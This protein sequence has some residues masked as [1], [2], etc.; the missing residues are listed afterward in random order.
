MDPVSAEDYGRAAIAVTVTTGF[1]LSRISDIEHADGPYEIEFRPADIDVR[2]ILNQRE[3]S[4]SRKKCFIGIR[5][6]PS[7][8][9]WVRIVAR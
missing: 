6:A 8:L 7:G 1:M 5:S 3:S 4:V 9:N 2:A